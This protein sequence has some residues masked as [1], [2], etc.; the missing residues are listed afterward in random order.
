MQLALRTVWKAG[1]RQS[2]RALRHRRPTLCPGPA[3]RRR[4]RPRCCCPPCAC[5]AR[6]LL[7]RRRRRLCLCHCAER[8][9]QCRRA[10]FCLCLLLLRCAC[11]RLHLHRRPGRSATQLHLP[12]IAGPDQSPRAGRHAPT[13]AKPRRVIVTIN[14]AGR[15]T[16]LKKCAPEYRL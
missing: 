7:R 14:T 5:G 6:A 4:L 11:S 2:H 12:P 9:G 10:H 16:L 1:R 15:S 13:C 3:A 8:R